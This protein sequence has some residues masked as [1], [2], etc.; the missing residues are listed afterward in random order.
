M[1]KRC[2]WCVPKHIIGPDLGEPYSDGLC[3]KAALRE[4]VKWYA[5]IWARR[6]EQAILPVALIYFAWQLLRW[7]SVGWRIIG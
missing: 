3:W 4:D 1:T 2:A 7:H 5:P 6:A